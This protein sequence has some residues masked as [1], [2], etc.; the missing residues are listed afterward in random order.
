MGPSTPPLGVHTSF[1]SFFALGHKMNANYFRGHVSLDTQAEGSSLHHKKL[2]LCLWLKQLE[3]CPFLITM[4][5]GILWV[6]WECSPLLL[7][8]L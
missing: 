5:N 6:V 8:F 1:G 2:L 7:T 4:A 3:F